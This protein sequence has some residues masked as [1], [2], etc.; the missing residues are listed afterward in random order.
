MQK[1][2]HEEMHSLTRKF[3]ENQKIPQTLISTIRL[4]GER[5]GRQD[6]YREQS[7]QTLEIM[8]QISIIQSTESSNRIEG[9]EVDPARLKALI[10]KKTTPIS[11]SEQEI[12]GYR[13]VLNTIHANYRNMNL[14]PGLIRQLH[15]D[16]LKFT[17]SPG[18]NWKQADNTIEETTP[19]GKKL[20]R[21]KPVPAFRV[22]DVM[23]NLNENFDKLLKD[24]NIEPLFLI[25]AY[26]FDF[27]C[28]HPFTDGNGRMSRL[29]S[30]LMLYQ[31]G[32]EV[33]RFISLEKIVE[34]NRETYYDALKKSSRNW[35]E[36]KH[37]L[38]PWWEFFLGVMV[39]G[40]YN[41]FEERVGLITTSRGSKSILVKDTIN[42]LRGEFSVKD[43]QEKCPNIGI[44][45]IRR[46]LKEER[47]KGNL[48]C[49]GRGPNAKWRR[50]GTIPIN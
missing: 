38:I 1:E 6:L 21:F 23:A 45:W 10:E 28:I 36:G 39:L 49:L 20:I 41:G 25:S 26:V 19:D 4:I 12:A 29:I 18:G 50:I 37:S 17:T 42:R 7:P 9:I 32:Y 48:E 44:D 8:T 27:L 15:R 22:N 5:K 3:I 43:I 14:T 33:G 35:H 46:I 24:S 40:A 31:A 11:R 13:D 16:M 34:E 47:E 2:K 30:L